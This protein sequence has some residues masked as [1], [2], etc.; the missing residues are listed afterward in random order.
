MTR[1]GTLACAVAAVLLVS[2][3][4]APSDSVA[5]DKATS[6]KAALARLQSYVGSWKGVG[7]PKRGSPTGAWTEEAEWAWHFADGRAELVAANTTSKFYDKLQLRPA[8]K[9]GQ[10]VLLATPA[11]GGELDSFA[12]SLDA[13][14]QL[15]VTAA[16]PREDAPAR[17]SIRQVAGGDRLIVLYEKLLGGDR[18]ARLAEVGSTR[19]G[20]S[21]G[22]GGDGYPECIVTGGRGSMKVEHAGKS[23]YVC[24]TGCRDEFL[25]HPE[26]IL[27]EYQARKAKD[28]EKK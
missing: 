11:G 8:D 2:A 18:Y 1:I 4:N 21:F 7:Q 10:F 27:A 16:K 17:I 23:Y 5:T 26:K 15:V 19:K 22:K 6:D 13:D 9:T 28:K 25:E 12:G 14:G 20:S 24:C 3:D